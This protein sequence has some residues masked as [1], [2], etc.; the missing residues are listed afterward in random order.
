MNVQGEN[1]RPSIHMP[2]WA[3]RILLEVTEVRVQRLQ[4][5][6]EQDALA[7]GVTVEV[8]EIG[9]KQPFKELWQSINSKRPGCDWQS[10]P[11]VWCV[12]F[13]RVETLTPADHGMVKLFIDAH[14]IQTDQQVNEKQPGHFLSARFRVF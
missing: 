13:K 3:S 2:R 7:E 8:R 6:Q 4:D 10:N 11:W 14:P 9:A 12:S 5:I 1:G